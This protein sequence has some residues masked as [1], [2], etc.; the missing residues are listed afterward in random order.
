MY[1]EVLRSSIC[2]KAGTNTIVFGND[3]ALAP[4]VDKVLLKSHGESSAVESIR[5]GNHTESDAWFTLGGVRMPRPAT[6]GIYVNG[7]RKYVVR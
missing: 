3:N 4:Y 5:S 2:L 7:G 1:S 6:T